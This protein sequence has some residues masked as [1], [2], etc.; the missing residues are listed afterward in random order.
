[1][2]FVNTPPE[3][4]E[5]RHNMKEHNIILTEKDINVI[6]QMIAFGQLEITKQMKKLS[7]ADYDIKEFYWFYRSTSNEIKRKLLD[8]RG[9]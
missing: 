7:K 4:V 2:I 9:Y 1:M 5:S 8:L 3:F 6:L